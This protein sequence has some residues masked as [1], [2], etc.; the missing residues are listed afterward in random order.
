M[1]PNCHLPGQGAA[2]TTSLLSVADAAADSPECAPLCAPKMLRIL[3][4]TDVQRLQARRQTYGN[5]TIG[6]LALAV[7]AGAALVMRQRLARA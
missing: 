5:V 7:F 1:P 3:T 2:V 6:A 4:A